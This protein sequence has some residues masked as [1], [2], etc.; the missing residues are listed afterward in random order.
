M[1]TSAFGRR[2]FL[3]GLLSMKNLSV[4]GVVLMAL[5]SPAFAAADC[6]DADP[7]IACG[8]NAIAG[9]PSNV[10]IGNNAQAVPADV[11]GAPLAPKNATA[12][13]A[14]AL[15]GPGS[16]AFGAWARAAGV[17]AAA[18]GRGARAMD[19]GT[20]I[21]SNALA[22]GATSVAVG[23]MATVQLTGGHGM[24]FGYA[25]NSAGGIAFGA[26]STA[27]D[28]AFAFGQAAQAT[29]F[30][31]LAVGLQSVA[32]QQSA[33]SFGNG[34]EATGG[35]TV[36]LGALARATASGAVAVGAGSVAD[37]ASTVA[38]GRGSAT[39]RLLYVTAG[40]ADTDAVNV[41]QLRAVAPALGGG[42]DVINGV[43]VNPIYNLSGGSFTNVGDALT[44]LD[45]RI[46]NI[47]LT[48]GPEGPAGPAGPV[49]QPG[50][51]GQNGR[52]GVAGAGASCS[53][54]VCY[55][56]ATKRSVTLNA[57]GSATRVSNV[58]EGVSRT[59]AANVGQLEA[60]VT[61]AV[62]TSNAYT[63]ARISELRGDMW[64]VDRNARGGIA[65]AM[66]IAGLPQAYAPGARMAAMAASGYRG[67]AGLAIGVS[68]V[69]DNGRWVYKVAGSSNTTGD[70]GMTVGAGIQW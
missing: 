49:G 41:F 13:G 14:G 53:E 70:F 38:F 28:G 37:E 48:P 39:R 16:T 9:D 15:A 1:V 64:E 25:A 63:D 67:E 32:S 23:R 44:Y 19:A 51:A 6:H 62:T 50:P 42:S 29:A 3:Q 54:A 2:T 66:A 31:A 34:A 57:G 61:R 20:A 4:F 11:N 36:A 35:N 18:F 56:D 10:A 43:F 22:G 24:A 8:E 58:S 26:L 30:G 52:D 47:A 33:A 55:D 27:A 60:G 69:T 46:T 65:S 40:V 12:V 21:G 68:G 45:G 17:D 5:A 59:D 7:G